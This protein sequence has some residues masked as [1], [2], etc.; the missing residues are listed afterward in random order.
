[1]FAFCVIATTTYSETGTAYEIIPSAKRKRIVP[2]QDRGLPPDATLR[3]FAELYLEYATKLWPELFADYGRSAARGHRQ[4]FESMV[5]VLKEKGD[6][7]AFVLIDDF[8]RGSRND[9]QWWQF[10]GICKN[11][12]IKLY[13][14]SD[15]FNL[16]DP[17]WEEMLTLY[18][19]MTRME[20][21]FRKMRVRRGLRGAAQ[22]HRVK[23]KL[24]LGFARTPELDSFGNPILKPD[25]TPFM[26]PCIHPDERRCR[27]KMYELFTVKKWS[28]YKITQFYNRAKIGGW[29]GWVDTGIRAT[30]ANPDALGVWIFNRT[31]SEMNFESEEYERKS[32]PRSEW[33]VYYDPRD[34]PCPTTP[35][36]KGSRCSR[37]CRSRILEAGLW[38]SHHPYR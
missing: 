34:H 23:G 20:A 14:A 35:A 26:V 37:D 22:R 10:A 27:E 4:G 17:N 16:Q 2:K 21:K 36:H 15:G 30:L 25:G 24:S 13:C 29:D 5:T 9:R 12:D 1:M 7:I 38:F 32:N 19:M 11:H 8:H 33:D 3:E 18:N 6:L 28:Y 31:Y